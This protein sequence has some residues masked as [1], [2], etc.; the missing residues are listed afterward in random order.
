MRLFIVLFK[1][2]SINLG[3]MTLWEW[4]AGNKDKKKENDKSS[5]IRIETYY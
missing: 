4:V 5:L 3:W 1:I 2:I